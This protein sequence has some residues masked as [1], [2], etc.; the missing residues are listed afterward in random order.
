MLKHGATH[1][2]TSL[3]VPR[4]GNSGGA[5]VGREV[6]HG[7]VDGLQEELGALEVHVVAGEAGGDL[8]EGALDGFAGV[9]VLEQ[10]GIVLDD[11]GDVVGAVVE[12]H[13]LVVHGGGAAAGPVLFGDMHALVGFGGFAAEVVVGVGHG[14]VLCIYR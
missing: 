8:A 9:E 14:W 5:G 2:A 13:D 1:G 3:G 10:E 12:A 4:S 7:V 6:A 11:G